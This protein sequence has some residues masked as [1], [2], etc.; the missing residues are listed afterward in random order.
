[1]A[2]KLRNLLADIC[3][4]SASY[5]AP[6]TEATYFRFVLMVET[7][8]ELSWPRLNMMLT[9]VTL[10]R[11][12]VLKLISATMLLGQRLIIRTLHIA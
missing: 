1:M 8:V 7:V 10:W 12:Y 11:R 2:V 5:R 4:R 9:I 6:V 3:G